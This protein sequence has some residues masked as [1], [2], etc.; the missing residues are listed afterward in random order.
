MRLVGSGVLC[1]I[2]VVSGTYYWMP[3]LAAF[4]ADPALQWTPHDSTYVST[5]GATAEM[6]GLFVAGPLADF[7][8]ARFILA[9]QANVVCMGILA[10]SVAKTPA[11]IMWTIGT[12]CFVKGVF[13]PTLGS[14]ISANVSPSKSDAA[15]IIVAMASRL[16]DTSSALIMGWLLTNYHFSWRKA[17][18]ALVV[19]IMICT[20]VSFAV[21]PAEIKAPAD[22]ASPSFVGQYEK[23]KNLAVSLD[24]WLALCILIGTYVVWA[25]AG[26][27]SPIYR[28]VY[29]VSS[30][31]AAGYSSVFTA[32]AFL[33]LAVAFLASQS[34]GTRR[35]R[36]CQLLQCAVG[37]I[38][39]FA[40]A[41]S[42]ARGQVGLTTTLSLVGCLGFGFVVPCYLPYLIY[43]ASSPV[44]ERAFRLATLDGLS[45]SIG[46]VLTYFFGNLR[47]QAASTQE[48]LPTMCSISAAGLSLSCIAMAILYRRLDGVTQHSDS[49]QETPAEGEA[50]PLLPPSVH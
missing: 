15:F 16:G 29:Y 35:G 22:R 32:T 10:V 38:A 34:L 13:W 3:L 25:F 24:G 14:L 48:V 27:L 23:L 46:V 47:A 31:T 42:F 9:V 43:A 45:C 19:M 1:T 21:S 18:L 40:L 5:L 11:M 26:Y 8:P 36:A 20:T 44:G 49:A 6:V 30:G 28:D 7:C 37:V 4:E 2:A 50:T 17:M 41:V 33:G 12:V 39:V